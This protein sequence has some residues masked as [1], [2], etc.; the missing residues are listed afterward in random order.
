MKDRAAAEPAG[1]GVMW[2][3]PFLSTVNVFRAKTIKVI[4]KTSGNLHAHKS[5]LI[6]SDTFRVNY[7][8]LMSQQGKVELH[9]VGI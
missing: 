3:G 7:Y 8:S 4:L 2:F 6:L 5:L 1:I 9:Q